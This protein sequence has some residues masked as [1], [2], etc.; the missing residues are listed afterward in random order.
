[1]EDRK[2]SLVQLGEYP[3]CRTCPTKRHSRGRNSHIERLGR[4][5]SKGE[6]G[7]V[8]ASPEHFGTAS[9]EPWVLDDAKNPALDFR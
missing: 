8:T 4:F 3:R 1:V 6:G 2:G 9:P 7:F 5:V